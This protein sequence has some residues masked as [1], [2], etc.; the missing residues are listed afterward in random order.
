MRTGFPAVP[1]CGA[2]RPV[3]PVTC[4]ATFS[5]LCLCQNRVVFDS[6]S[7]SQS[8]DLISRVQ[9]PL[10]R[11]DH[12]GLACVMPPAEVDRVEDRD[13]STSF[14]PKLMVSTRSTT[15][16][17]SSGAS[18]RTRAAGTSTP[19]VR[20]DRE[21][22]HHLS[23]QARV[24]AQ[25]TVVEPVQRR[26][27]AVETI[28]I[29][30]SVRAACAPPASGRSDA[31]PPALPPIALV[32]RVTW[33]PAMPRCRPG[34]SAI[35]ALA[36]GS[37]V[38]AAARTACVG[39]QHRPL[40][41]SARVVV[42]IADTRLQAQPGDV[43]G[44]LQRSSSWRKASSPF[45]ASRPGPP[46]RL[47]RLLLVDP[48]RLLRHDLFLG[49]LRLRELLLRFRTAGGGAGGIGRFCIIMRTTRSGTCTVSSAFGSKAGRWWARAARRSG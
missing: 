19:A 48:G 43:L 22:Q 23:A 12:A 5:M 4:V 24:L 49:R 33:T 35:E 10:V 21:A 9:P 30:S 2:R 41:P 3:R 14:A 7:A 42:G 6:S 40:R 1:L 38:D 32:A 15:C 36:E 37:Q 27:V 29:S 16:A 44:I 18:C 13:R 11:C 45:S 47:D 31:P 17:E 20:L 39:R 28:W 26:L 34:R 46:G 25:L 8:R